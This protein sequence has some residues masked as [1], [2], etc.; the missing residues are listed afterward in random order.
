MFGYLWVWTK[1]APHVLLT[2]ILW[3]LVAKEVGRGRKLHV[4]WS[5]V[6]AEVPHGGDA[7]ASSSP[8]KTSSGSSSPNPQPLR[9]IGG[10][11]R[12][13]LLL[14]PPSSPPPTHFKSFVSQTLRPSFHAT[15]PAPRFLRHNGWA[16]PRPTTRR[17]AVPFLPSSAPGAPMPWARPPTPLRPPRHGP[18]RPIPLGPSADRMI[19]RGLS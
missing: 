7:R 2:Y 16:P 17:P 10:E 19:A 8:R 13:S 1:M 4:S 15:P 6:A 18:L 5:G 3:G 14:P 9:L 11:L 12:P